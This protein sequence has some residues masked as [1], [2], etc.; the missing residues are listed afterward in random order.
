MANAIEYQRYEAETE[1]WRLAGPLDP[2]SANQSSDGRAAL[3]VAEGCIYL[4][5][6]EGWRPRLQWTESGIK[7]SCD[8]ERPSIQLTGILK[9]GG[10]YVVGAEESTDGR[11]LVRWSPESGDITSLLPADLQGGDRPTV[12]QLFTLNDE[13][14]VY[15]TG[16]PYP[17]E[18]VDRIFRIHEGRW[19]KFEPD[20]IDEEEILRGEFRAYGDELI[21]MIQCHI[22]QDESDSS[23]FAQWRPSE[24][25]FEWIDL[26]PGVSPPS[27]HAEHRGFHTRIGP[28]LSTWDRLWRYDVRSETWDTIGSPY[29]EGRLAPIQIAVGPR[30]VYAEGPVGSL[31]VTRATPDAGGD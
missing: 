4:R 31:F 3:D 17:Y 19:E 20:T 13:L 29:V 8:P 5:E 14:W 25:R 18:W 24:N 21:V 30:S 9:H 23:C 27:T 16:S 26:P 6:A 7:R 1:Q 22:S 28:M 15:L 12:E 11:V 2:W 10:G